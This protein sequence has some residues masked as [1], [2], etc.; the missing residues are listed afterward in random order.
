MVIGQ[1]EVNAMDIGAKKLVAVVAVVAFVM[2]VTGRIA[3]QTER[4][5]DAMQ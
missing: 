4:N 1:T 3:T 2:T 5:R